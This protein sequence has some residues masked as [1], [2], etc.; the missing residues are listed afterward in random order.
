[1]KIN[2]RDVTCRW[3]NLDRDDKNAKEME[4]QFEELGFKN[5]RRFSARIVEPPK[6]TPQNIRHHVGCAQSHIDILEDKS[7]GTPL[8]IL[9]DDVVVTPWYKDTIEVPDDTDAV[10]L[11]ISHGNKNYFA[12]DVSEP[13]GEWLARI[14]GVFATH[15][16]LY[17]TDKY[18]KATID[19]A[20]E[21]AYNRNIPFD[22]GCSEIQKSFKVL[23]P[24]LPFFAQSDDR[25]SE[26]KWG[27]MTL[28][29]LQMAAFG[30]GPLGPGYGKGTQGV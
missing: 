23:T 7:N 5:Q 11:G 30:Q 28:Q 4:K 14:Q 21:Y 29:P 17:L 24:H 2:I 8:L 1:M 13:D 12:Q 19:I 22:V 26:S 3:I 9:E 20:K 15:A 16:I 25:R 10:Y 6:A 27:A 18:K